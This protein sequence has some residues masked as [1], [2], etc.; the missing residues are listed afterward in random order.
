MEN[1]TKIKVIG[2]GGSGSNTVSR[3]MASK[4]K[5]VELIAVNTDLQH[6]KKTR[7]HKK[8]RIGQAETMGLGAGMDPKIGEK[9]AEE[10]RDAIRNCLSGADLVFITCGLGGGT[11]TG[12]SP[13]V[14]SIL[15]EMKILTVAVVTTPFS[16]EGCKRMMIARAGLEKMENKVD[17]LISISNDKLFVAIESQAS[18]DSAFWM[19]D[20]I[21][22]QAVS[23]I[24]DLIVLP[25]IVN[26][27]FADVRTILKNAGSAIFGIGKARGER[28]A[29]EA[30]TAAFNSPLIDVSCKEAKGVLFNVSGGDDISLSEINEIAQTIKEKVSPNARIIFGAVHD[31]KLKKEEIKVTIVVTGF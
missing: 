31:E 21:L 13:V 9:A 1:I 25:G 26:I 18:V 4:I 28:R 12:A 10:S 16:F 3:M 6:L 11:G 24:S 30:V 19:C 15:Q 27:D 23:G 22:R 5:G 8:I 2:I 29:K 20:E 7:A 17:A 14:A